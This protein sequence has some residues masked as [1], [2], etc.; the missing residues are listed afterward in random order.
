MRRRRQSCRWYS[1]PNQNLGDRPE[2]L[3][4]DFRTRFRFHIRDA[5]WTQKRVLFAS[6]W[7]PP[8]PSKSFGMYGGDDGARTRDLCRDSIPEG[9]NPLE[10]GVVDGNLSALWNPRQ[11]LLHPY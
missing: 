2:A 4:R 1:L 7:I 9:R 6:L 3:D 11:R 5:N 10:T 8:I